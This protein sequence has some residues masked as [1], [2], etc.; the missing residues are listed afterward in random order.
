M[1]G[2]RLREVIPLRLYIWV[3][4]HWILR[5]KQ[6]ISKQ[7]NKQRNPKSQGFVSLRFSMSI[8]KGRG[9]YLWPYIVT[10]SS[11]SQNTGLTLNNRSVPPLKKL[12]WGCC[13]SSHIPDP[14]LFHCTGYAICPMTLTVPQN[15][16]DKPSDFCPPTLFKLHSVMEEIHHTL[17]GSWSRVLTTLPVQ[18]SGGIARQCLDA[19]GG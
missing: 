16:L 3:Q 4:V 15:I 14:L 11:M 17:S 1:R 2:L 19:W 8:A 18:Q 7:T 10:H 5:K 9:E 12:F 13:K 6:N